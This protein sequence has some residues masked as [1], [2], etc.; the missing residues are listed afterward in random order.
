MHNPFAFLSRIHD[1]AC[2][3][4]VREKMIPFWQC[5]EDFR[6]KRYGYEFIALIPM[7]MFR[8]YKDEVSTRF[9]VEDDDEGERGVMVTADATQARW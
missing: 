9:I 8:G 2:G 4:P 3:V 1:E 6:G 7:A 5:Y